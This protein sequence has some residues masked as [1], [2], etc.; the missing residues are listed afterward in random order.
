MESFPR[1]DPVQARPS[2]PLPR[3]GGRLGGT[4]R[5]TGHRCPLS[6]LDDLVHGG[7]EYINVITDLPPTG[8]TNGC[9]TRPA[10]RPSTFGR[11]SSVHG[12]RSSP[13]PTCEL[14]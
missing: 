14:S 3:T 9:A 4:R 11:R 12:A 7:L 5:R 8:F 6:Y 1:I 2:C 13:G 10:T